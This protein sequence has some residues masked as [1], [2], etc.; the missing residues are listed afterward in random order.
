MENQKECWKIRVH[1][2]GGGVLYLQSQC[3]P[4][5]IIDTNDPHICKRVKIVA[6]KPWPGMEIA[7][8]DWGEAAAVTW[9]KADGIGK[10]KTSRSSFRDDSL[11]ALDAAVTASGGTGATT[12]A[13]AEQL[14][15]SEKTVRRW[16]TKSRNWSVVDGKVYDRGSSRKAEIDL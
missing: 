2:R 4:V 6:F 15:S 11:K 3:L 8:V 1:L 7:Y 13:V 9:W 5:L 12:D 16:I 14:G 10:D